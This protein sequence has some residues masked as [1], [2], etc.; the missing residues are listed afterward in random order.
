[1]KSLLALVVALA[2]L[3]FNISGAQEA[4]G[5]NNDSVC[6]EFVIDEINKDL[7]FLIENP[8]GNDSAIYHLT[9]LRNRILAKMK[10][11]EE[12]EDSRTKDS[13]IQENINAA[14][15][16]RISEL[17]QERERLLQSSNE[18]NPIII[19]LDKEI[20]RLEIEKERIKK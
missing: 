5:E 11:E 8:E 14:I 7:K 4:A 3:S 6:F 15:Q 1:M 19:N 16:D 13:I 18:T 2:L 10:G 12:Y 17:Q 9:R 20:K